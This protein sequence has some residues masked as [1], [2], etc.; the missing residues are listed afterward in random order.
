[1][2][3]HHTLQSCKYNSIPIHIT[4]IHWSSRLT[5]SILCSIILCSERE[6][7]PGSCTYLLLVSS[8]TDWTMIPTCRQCPRWTP[9]TTLC[10]WLCCI[11]LWGKSNSPT[12]SFLQRALS[13][14]IQYF[15]TSFSTMHNC[16]RW[17]CHYVGWQA[18]LSICEDVIP[19]F[20]IGSLGSKL[21]ENQFL[22]PNNCSPGW[23]ERSIKP[24]TRNY[25]SV[26][27]LWNLMLSGKLVLRKCP[28]S[29]STSVYVWSN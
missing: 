12:L 8:K 28:D 1:M 17:F 14:S 27:I 10:T 22:P 21:N 25:L 19:K 24:S 18:Q 20:L 7:N 29:H 5:M 26:L 16:S 15:L 6:T 11:Y 2:H 13:P 4:F 3:F 9:A 23:F